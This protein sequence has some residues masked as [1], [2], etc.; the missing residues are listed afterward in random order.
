MDE[1]TPGYP[2]VKYSAA[3]AAVLVDSPEQEQQLRGG[4]WADSPAAFGIITC[5]SVEEMQEPNV[6]RPM[7]YA[8]HAWGPPVP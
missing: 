8:P 7:P 1:Y 3:G 4:P 5:P 2:K 6:P